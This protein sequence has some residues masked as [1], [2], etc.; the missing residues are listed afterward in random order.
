MTGRHKDLLD[1]VV[2]Q[3]ARSMKAVRTCGV[4]MAPRHDLAVVG[5]LLLAATTAVTS[6]YIGKRI[7]KLSELQHGVRGEV[8][9]VDSRT[10]HVKGFSYDG[11]APDAFFYGGFSGLP[12][13]E[14]FIIPDENGSTQPLGRYRNKDVTLTLP[15]GITLKD[16]KWISVWCRAFA[17]DFG[18]VIVPSGLQYPRPQKINALSTLDHGVSSDRLVVVDAQTFLIPNF[19]YD[20]AAPDAHFWVGRGAK[21]GPDGSIVPDE[22]GATQPLKRYDAK[23]IVI[24]L[25]DHLTVFDIDYLSVWCKDFFADFGHVRIPS[26]LNVPPSLKMLGVAPQSGSQRRGFSASDLPQDVQSS[27]PLSPPIH[28]EVTTFRPRN[29]QLHNAPPPTTIRPT[30]FSR[31]VFSIPTPQITT[32]RTTTLKSLVKTGL[33]TA[34][35][36]QTLSP[37]VPTTFRPRPTASRKRPTP[38]P[39]RPPSRPVSKSTPKPSRPRSRPVSKS[40]PRPARP[41]SRPV[42]KSTPKPLSPLRTPQT[43]PRSRLRPTPKVTSQNRQIVPVT[44]QSIVDQN[45][46]SSDSRVENEIIPAKSISRARN[47][48]G[49]A[50]NRRPAVGTIR[51]TNT[52]K[53]VRPN[54]NSRVNSV[55]KSRKVTSQNLETSENSHSNLNRNTPTQNERKSI[56]QNRGRNQNF[57]PNTSPL[58]ERTLNSINPSNGNSN[59]AIF[60][61]I[62]Q[63]PVK[64]DTNNVGT[65]TGVSGITSSASDS[66]TL[67]RAVNSLLPNAH[68]WDAHLKAHAKNAG[69]DNWET[70][71]RIASELEELNDLSQVE[72]NLETNQ[73][74]QNSAPQTQNPHSIKILKFAPNFNSQKRHE[75]NFPTFPKFPDFPELVPFSNDENKS[76]GKSLKGNSLI[77]D[78]ELVATHPGRSQ[79]AFGYSVS[80]SY[81]LPPDKNGQIGQTFQIN[82]GAARSSFTIYG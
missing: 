43:I 28:Q 80:S 48:Q 36:G 5:L 61:A 81:V 59:N 62:P 19:S 16:V 67:L 42:S 44:P 23:T 65:N 45:N 18:H 32:V 66:T 76:G 17:I 57:R 50:N 53:S 41:R 58:N 31:R 29:R 38:R 77:T 6:Q 47:L 51:P 60:L 64:S 78:N 2:G 73:F 74:T 13:D 33:S 30:T 14:G 3:F 34:R 69:E 71:N 79:G 10:I 75:Q 7:G 56:P 11:A 54:L 15:E 40:T 8:Y 55:S 21:P 70:S 35:R 49:R 20:G 25:P 1:E 82:T 24:T 63:L 22:N 68:N 12:S 26:T 72:R 39:S 52:A 9:A 27:L 4:K 37:V 46:K